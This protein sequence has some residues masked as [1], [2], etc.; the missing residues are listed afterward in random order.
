MICSFHRRSGRGYTGA[1]LPFSRVSFLSLPAD[2]YR[3]LIAS[4][5]EK[6]M[7]AKGLCLPERQQA[8]RKRNP[9]RRRTNHEQDLLHPARRHFQPPVRPLLG[10]PLTERRIFRVK[11]CFFVVRIS[12]YPNHN[13]Q[14]S[15]VD[16]TLRTCTG[17][18]GAVSQAGCNQKTRKQ[19]CCA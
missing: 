11:I 8:T 14:H 7:N 3:F 9:H 17:P 18:R 15:G 13:R 4:G 2:E 10:P 16:N 1:D 5:S 6:Y 12:R 19:T